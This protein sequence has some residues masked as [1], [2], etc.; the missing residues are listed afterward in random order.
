MLM[1]E[2]LRGAMFKKTVISAFAFSFVSTS[3]FAD[4]QYTKWGMTT[5]EVITAS[6]NEASTPSKPDIIEGGVVEHLL[7]A[8]YSTDSL[9]FTA[10]FW[11]GKQNNKL[12]MVELKL[13]DVNRCQ[14]LINQLN[15]I[16]GYNKP[17]KTSLMDFYGWKDEKSGNTVSLMVLSDRICDL[18]YQPIAKPTEKGL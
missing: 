3:A 11:F 8:P 7:S 12:K 17:E 4:W 16:Y 9:D 5:E 14:H 10:N 2:F 15:L 13:S 6:G 1:S 18:R